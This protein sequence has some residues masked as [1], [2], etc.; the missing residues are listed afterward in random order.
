MGDRAGNFV[1]VPRNSVNSV[2]VEEGEVI[3]W[4]RKKKL[5]K[6]FRMERFG[7]VDIRK[8]DEL[9]EM[10]RWLREAGRY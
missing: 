3:C 9:C 10:E 1:E 8:R 4:D 6:E 5:K 2:S 7:V